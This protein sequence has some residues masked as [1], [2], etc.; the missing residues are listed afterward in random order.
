MG[1]Q[2][3]VFNFMVERGGKL[4][5]SL[6]CAK[7]VS[8]PINF[9]SLKYAPALEKDTVQL[10]QTVGKHKIPRYLYHMTSL[11]NYNKMLESGCIRPSGARL[12]DGVYMLEL[13][14]FSKYW[15]KGL[16]N[17]LCDMVF[18]SGEGKNIIMLKVPTKKLKTSQ[19]RLRT[20]KQIDG[21]LADEFENEW[22]NIYDIPD[23]KRR[24]FV[25]NLILKYGKK[26]ASKRYL[27]VIPKKF[28]PITKGIDAK[29]TPLYKQKKSDLE[30]I[31]GDKIPM[32]DVE[33]VGQFNY[34]KEVGTSYYS[35]F[36]E[37][38]LC[39]TIFEK[40]FRGK[41]EEPFLKGWRE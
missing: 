1:I 30:F 22:W 4:A 17:Q 3:V 41:P 37:R 7:P 12:P 9:K 31:Y 8:K 13:D 35:D 24:I 40:I 27:E 39:K 5:K 32:S 26:E 11:E 15:S 23:E 21:K 20:Q 18:R 10:S 2:K 38:N 28:D 34:E 36:E 19:I 14:S 6:L 16:R 25:E 33:L 29:L